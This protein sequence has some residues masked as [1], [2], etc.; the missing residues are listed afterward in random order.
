MKRED[1]QT[2]AALANSNFSISNSASKYDPDLSVRQILE[3]FND[4]V[5]R[6]KG[7]W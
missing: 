1:I 4:K 7:N 6:K 2:F 5:S 3:L